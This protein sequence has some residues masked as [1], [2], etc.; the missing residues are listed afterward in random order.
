MTELRPAAGLRATAQ[1]SAITPTP[2][3]STVQASTP[4]GP[5]ARFG[6]LQPTR[7]QLTQIPI[8]ARR[9][10]P[11]GARAVLHLRHTPASRVPAIRNTGN[12]RGAPAAAGEYPSRR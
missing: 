5:D 4:G 2:P 6:V 10:G 1:P 8:P 3:R 11:H 7:Q 12:D 9:T